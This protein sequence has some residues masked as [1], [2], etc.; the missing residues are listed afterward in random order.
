MYISG[1]GKDEH[2]INCGSGCEVTCFDKR[3]EV[4]TEPSRP[5]CFCKPGFIRLKR[6]GPCVKECPKRKY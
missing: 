1:C 4:C 2:F 3:P 6:G 5:G